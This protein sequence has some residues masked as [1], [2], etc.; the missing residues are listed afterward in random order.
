[1]E[2]KEKDEEENLVFKLRTELKEVATCPQNSQNNQTK[3]TI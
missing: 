3:S 2:E 1:M